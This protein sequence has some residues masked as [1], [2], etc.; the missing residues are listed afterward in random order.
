MGWSAT[1]GHPAA[2]G[3][4]GDGAN[5]RPSSSFCGRP[6]ELSVDSNPS[7][8]TVSPVHDSSPYGRPRS[9]D[10]RTRDR[11]PA[12]S[13]V[14]TRSIQSLS[15]TGSSNKWLSRRMGT[16]HPSRGFD[17]GQIPGGQCPLIEPCSDLDNRLTIRRSAEFF[18]RANQG[19]E[20]PAIAG[21][22][23][24]DARAGEFEDAGVGQASFEGGVA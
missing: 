3:R 5:Y 17:Q 19:E 24:A 9:A 21:R 10:W 7:C 1:A 6:R 12:N 13:R 15:F 11:S 16:T 22:I 18:R 20:L 8:L 2:E 4:K 14:F 23:L